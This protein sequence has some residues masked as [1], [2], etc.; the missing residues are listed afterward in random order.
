[1]GVDVGGTWI[2]VAVVH[3]DGRMQ[4]IARK[5]TAV[6]DLRIFLLTTVRQESP[7][8]RQ[9]LALVVASRGVWTPRERGRIAAALRGVAARVDVISDAQAAL[10]GA[11]G[12]RPGVLVLAGTGSIV[13]GRGTTDRWARAGGLGP[14]L[15]DDGSGF[16]LGR[17]WLRATTSSADFLSAR[18]LVKSPD[19]VARIAALAPDVLRRARRGDRRARAIVRDGAH[20]LAALAVDV[21]RQLRLAPPVAISWAGSVMRDARYRAAVARALSR[22]GVRAQWTAPRHEALA[23]AAQRAAQ[24]AGWTT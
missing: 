6:P 16:W 8:R 22:A 24:L 15:G 1:M 7:R 11:L 5:A 14:L 13:L 10:L 21:T 20:R 12:H 2:R 3:P 23:A 18:R 19:A 17:E 9:A 4:R